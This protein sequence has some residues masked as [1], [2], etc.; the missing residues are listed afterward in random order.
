MDAASYRQTN[1]KEE[2]RAPRPPGF[3]SWPL[4]TTT[5]GALTLSHTQTP[6]SVPAG[7]AP[8]PVI[9]LKL[10]RWWGRAGNHWCW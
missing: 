6:D 2:A 4:V 5:T 9:G 8:A 1:D 7:E 3:P 10:A